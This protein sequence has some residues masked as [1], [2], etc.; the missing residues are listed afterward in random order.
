M[1]IQTNCQIFYRLLTKNTLRE[2]HFRL[3]I[4]DLLYGTKP[5]GRFSW[6]SVFELFTKLLSRREFRE[7]QLSDILLKVIN[8][9]PPMVSIF[10][11][12][13]R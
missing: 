12:R 7:N 3:F 13:F 2:E 11:V 9:L 4:R 10:L 5:L 6:N 8:V 1:I